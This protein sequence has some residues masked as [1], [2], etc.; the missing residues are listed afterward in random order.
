MGI[1]AILMF[2]IFFWVVQFKRKYPGIS[3]AEEAAELYAKAGIT[4]K[5]QV[6]FVID[7]KLAELD[8]IS[9]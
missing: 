9:T 5:E 4:L 3:V 2:T 8:S 1:G 6:P 7:T